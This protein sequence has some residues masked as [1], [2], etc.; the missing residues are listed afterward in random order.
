[1]LR[2]API[3]PED[4]VILRAAKDLLR[5]PNRQTAKQILR[6]AQDDSLVSSPFGLIS[7]IFV[8][9]LLS[10]MHRGGP[11]GPPLP[12]YGCSSENASAL[13]RGG[14]PPSGER[15]VEEE[16][17]PADLHMQIEVGRGAGER[18]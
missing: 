4:L 8:Y 17:L 13:R 18:V 9:H 12:G 16:A 3:Y 11:E 1:M 7:A 15:G 10:L 14:A 2:V 6:C 5:G